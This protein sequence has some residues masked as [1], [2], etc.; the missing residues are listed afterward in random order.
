MSLLKY[1][2]DDTRL[3]PSTP[4]Q[5][6][7]SANLELDG[8][9][10]RP[11]SPILTQHATGYLDPTTPL[12]GRQARFS[13]EP[14]L[15]VDSGY[16]WLVCFFCILGNLINGGQLFSFGVYYDSLMDSFET[17]LSTTA[18]VGSACL[19]FAYGACVL[20][21]LLVDK[22]GHWR[23]SM[24]G[25]LLMCGGIALTGFVPR[26]EYSFITYGLLFGTGSALYFMACTISF[27][28]LLPEIEFSVDLACTQTYSSSVST[29][30][31]DGRL[32]P[33]L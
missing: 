24:V 21:G 30:R 10:S 1:D 18:W 14:P 13:Q 23:T 17:S 9:V 27:A 20:G 3:I 25:G 6:P 5:R 12:L 19:C 31:R 4:P 8:G 11:D 15:S 7:P 33:D 2:D 28:F 32:Q 16:A 22:Y 26:I 29:L